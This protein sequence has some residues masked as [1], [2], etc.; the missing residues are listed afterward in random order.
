MR[1]CGF[2]LNDE[3][4]WARRFVPVQRDRGGGVDNPEGRTK[5]QGL[6]AQAQSWEE[7]GAWHSLDGME[8]HRPASVGR[9]ESSWDRRLTPR[10]QRWLQGTRW[11]GGFVGILDTNLN[12]HCF[13]EHTEIPLSSILVN[14]IGR[15]STT[16]PAA[17]HWASQPASQ[18]VG[19]G[20][21]GR[22]PADH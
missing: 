3:G 4:S 5:G 20:L 10:D 13:H 6:G 8:T 11:L 16:E 12:S 2:G 1:A 7:V 22:P 19:V 17:L 18:P 15:E 14:S 9:G 21:A